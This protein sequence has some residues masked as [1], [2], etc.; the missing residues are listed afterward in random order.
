MSFK[1]SLENN[2]VPIV[3]PIN[4]GNRNFKS[5]T[6]MAF[7]VLLYIPKKSIIYEKLIAGKINANARGSAIINNVVKPELE[8]ST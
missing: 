5:K 1:R 7:N 4:N 3:T 6:E 2:K 8:K